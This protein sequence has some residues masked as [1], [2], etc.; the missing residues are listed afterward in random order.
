MYYVGLYS[1]LN[2]IGNEC[3]LTYNRTWNCWRCICYKALIT[4]MAKV[5]NVVNQADQRLKLQTFHQRI[6]DSRAITFWPRKKFGVAIIASVK[7]LERHY[8]TQAG[9]A[10]VRESFYRKLN[11]RTTSTLWFV[12]TTVRAIRLHDFPL[13]NWRLRGSQITGYYKHKSFGWDL[14]PIKL[15]NQ[16]A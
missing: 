1:K 3:T 10:H 2:K 4:K 7:N 9:M 12:V 13:R 6:W 5:D 16:I 8:I 11:Q 14:K 15:K